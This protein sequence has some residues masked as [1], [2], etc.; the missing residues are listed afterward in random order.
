LS[1]A[2]SAAKAILEWPKIAKPHCSDR[3]KPVSAMRHSAS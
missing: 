3:N 1:A 2:A